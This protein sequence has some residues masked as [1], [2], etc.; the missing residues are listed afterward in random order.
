MFSTTNSIG[1]LQRAAIFI[2]SYT[3]P[4]PNVPSPRKAMATAPVCRRFSARANACHDRSA[5]S[6]NAIRVKIVAL[7][8]LTATKT[9]AY[10]RWAGRLSSH[11][12]FDISRIAEI[13]PVSPV[14]RKQDVAL[15]IDR[16]CN[17]NSAGFLPQACM[18]RPR[19][20]PPREHVQEV[21]FDRAH[22]QPCQPKDRTYP[23]SSCVAGFA[24]TLLSPQ[25]LCS[26]DSL[27]ETRKARA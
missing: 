24:W 21:S 6:L 25:S 9:S 11:Q 23:P 12:S 7:D 20:Q 13:M 1:K 15:E 16:R 26:V 8:V 5:R 10:S 3:A 2:A 22:H 17:S 27:R 18:H 4:S 19:E 14:I